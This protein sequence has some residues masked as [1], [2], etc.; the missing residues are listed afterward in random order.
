MQ[1]AVENPRYCQDYAGILHDILFMSKCSGRSLDAS[2]KIFRVI[3]QGAGRNKYH[4]LKLMVGPGDQ[5]EPVIT[6][7]LASED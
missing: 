4:D 2:T 7:M 3:I 5:R 1:K 6:I